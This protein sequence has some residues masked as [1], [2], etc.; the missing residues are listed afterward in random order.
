MLLVELP[1]FLSVGLGFPISE[2]AVLSAL[3]FLCNWLF[4]MLYSSCLDKAMS[5][6]WISRTNARKLSQAI[7]SITPAVCLIGVCLSGCE[8]TIVVPLMVIATTSMGTMFSGVFSNQNDLA[9]NYAGVL[10]GI[11]NMA[12]TIPGFAVPAIVGALTHG[13]PGIGPW[14]VAFYLTAGLLIFEILVFGIFG[15]ANE[16]PWNNLNNPF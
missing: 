2:N 3:P 16:Q 5:Q 14:H 9:S 7:A 10:M 4:S 6:N 15:S 13:T 11:T 8:G 1:M 12:A